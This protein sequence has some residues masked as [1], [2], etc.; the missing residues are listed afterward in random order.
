LLLSFLDSSFGIKS[1]CP[2]PPPLISLSL[3]GGLMMEKHHVEI[4]INQ[5]P[6]NFDSVEHIMTP[7]DKPIHGL[8]NVIHPDL[9]A[10][11][12]IRLQLSNTT[13]WAK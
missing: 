7:N 9:P 6:L 4:G 1:S 13:E 2:K 3:E 8:C 10:K 5:P 11:I 12:S